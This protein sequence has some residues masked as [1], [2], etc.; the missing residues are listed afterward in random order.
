M[1]TRSAISAWWA[2]W[3]WVAI[4]AGLLA[5]CAVLLGS[6][7]LFCL[8][9]FFGGGYAAV[10]LVAIVVAAIAGLVSRFTVRHY[11]RMLA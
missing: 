11:L 1:I 5:M 8:S 6:F 10:V 9:T 7:W 4:L 2:A 3:K